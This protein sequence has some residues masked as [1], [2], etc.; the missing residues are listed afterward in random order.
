MRRYNNN[1]DLLIFPAKFFITTFRF[2]DIV[3]R[4]CLKIDFYDFRIDN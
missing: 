4:K 2:T 1:R 3:V